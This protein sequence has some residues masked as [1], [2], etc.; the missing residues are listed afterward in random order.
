M[1]TPPNLH[2][3]LR[4]LI[5]ANHILH[6]HNLVDAFG[7]ISIRHPLHP[8]QYLIAAYD[9]GAPALVKQA[10]DFI[11]YWIHDSTPVDPSAPQGYSERYIHSE[12]LKR[13]PDANCVVH[14]H[15]E[16]VI[17]F[18]LG[19]VDVKPVFHMAGFLGAKPL[20][21]F[22]IAL[23]YAEL[24]SFE[25][26]M[27]VK[28]QLL[29]AALAEK[30][31]HKQPV[32]LQHKHGFTTFGASIEEAVYRAM[33]TQTNCV[34]LKEAIALAGGDAKAVAYLLEEEA[35]A[36]AVMNRKTQDKSFRLWLREVQVNPLYENEEGEPEKGEVAGM[37]M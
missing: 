11:T 8:D 13:F 26:D 16:V 14:S 9:P 18:T 17:P 23:V 28:N 6:Q 20:P 15:S 12:V 37:K 34:L 31:S 3:Q 22:D 7:H 19:S 29:G 36:C 10:S 35:E 1:S 5:R 4:L 27:L 33:Y 2:Q 25:P 32:A 30:L 21:V 24:R